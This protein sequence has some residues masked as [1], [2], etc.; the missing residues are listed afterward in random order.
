LWGPLRGYLNSGDGV[1]DLAGNIG[2]LIQRTG[3]RVETA[4]AELLGAK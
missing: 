4:H 2:G 3:K 1:R